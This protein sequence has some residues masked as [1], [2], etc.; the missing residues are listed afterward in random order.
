TAL[1]TSGNAWMQIGGNGTS[2]VSLAAINAGPHDLV[3]H[4]GQNTRLTGNATAGQ[5]DINAHN[6]SIDPGAGNTSTEAAAAVRTTGLVTVTSG[7]AEFGNVV[8]TGARASGVLGEGLVEQRVGGT[9]NRNAST[10]LSTTIQPG[11]VAANIP[12]VNTDAGPVSGW[13]SNST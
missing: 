5:L 4:A 6:F 7:T 3:V 10:A 9:V 13:T 8:I 12:I 1:N 2:R 11:T